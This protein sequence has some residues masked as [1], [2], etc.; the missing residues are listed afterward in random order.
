LE[1]HAGGIPDRGSRFC[2]P[3]NDRTKVQLFQRFLGFLRTNI[4][5]VRAATSFR[6]VTYEDVFY[7][8]QAIAPVILGKSS[9]PMA[10]EYWRHLLEGMEKGLEEGITAELQ[11]DRDALMSYGRGAVAAFLDD[12]HPPD[13]DCLT[14]LADVCSD[15]EV[16]R[17]QFFTLNHDTVLE[18]LLKKQKI[19]YFDGL[20]AQGG[21]I[22][23]FEPA[24]YAR[25]VPKVL[26]YKLHGSV[27]WKFWG[28]AGSG[29]SV[30]RVG[31]ILETLPQDG[32][33][34]SFEEGDPFPVILVGTL[35]KAADYQWGPFLDLIYLFVKCLDRTDR[36]I[37]CG[38]SFGDRFIGGHLMD[39]QT[40]NLER[41]RFVV[42]DRSA[43]ELQR[44]LG[45]RGF[46]TSRVFGQ[47]KGIGGVTWQSL[48]NC[49][50]GH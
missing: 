40:K 23:W 24:G 17:V 50:S 44:R 20:D 4:E 38:H 19:E 39:W 16:E 34:T 49:L 6:R 33:G 1:Y 13:L 47:G 37:V 48:K 30:D 42:V 5:D 15:P 27:D 28:P 7:V 8:A 18:R 25:C 12:Y 46:A 41:R 35:N 26:V 2:D 22:R 29:I 11:G 3:N 36:L 21:P 32:A 31:S 45:K 43:D 9:D 14:V 10:I